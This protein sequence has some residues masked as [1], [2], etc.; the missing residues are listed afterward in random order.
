MDAVEKAAQ[1]L[2]NYMKL[3]GRPQNADLLL[4]LGSIDERVAGWAAELSLRY[5]YSCVMFSGGIAHEGDLLAKSWEGSEAQHFYKVFLAS[6]GCAERVIL[7]EQ[8]QNTGQ[9]VL[10]SYKLLHE[11]GFGAT[12][13][14]V[15]LVTKPY[16]ERRAMA[17]FACQWPVPQPSFFVTS[18]NLTFKNYPNDQQPYEKLLN[19]MVGDMQRIIDY[20]SRGWQIEQKIPKSVMEAY[21][22]L[23]SAGHTEHNL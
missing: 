23:A 5:N 2:W 3:G 7:E 9:N 16:M 20:P 8:A 1:T 4:V 17:T 12:I 6:G 18:P 22:L 14:K 13:R 21:N 11:Q 10:F 19:I 15:Q